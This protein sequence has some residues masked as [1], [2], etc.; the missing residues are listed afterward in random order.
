MTD[1]IPSCSRTV[2]RE[3][4]AGGDWLKWKHHDAVWS[5]GQRATT[6]DKKGCLIV[7]DC[8]GCNPYVRNGGILA[9]VGRLLDGNK[10]GKL[11]QRD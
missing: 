3:T 9:G 5:I 1:S 4:Q 8:A 7:I 10:T 2:E 6:R 11:E